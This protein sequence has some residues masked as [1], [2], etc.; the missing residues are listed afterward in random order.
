M[1]PQGLSDMHVPFCETVIV[2]FWH[3]KLSLNLLASVHVSC[4]HSPHRA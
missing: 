3:S 1:R 2:Q 4:R